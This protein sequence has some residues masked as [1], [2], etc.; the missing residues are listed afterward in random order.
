MA[1]VHELF[2]TP[3]YINCLTDFASTAFGVSF[4]PVF[5]TYVQI[6]LC[7]VKVAE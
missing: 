1:L 5:L 6:I 4:G 7:S 3:S 2:D